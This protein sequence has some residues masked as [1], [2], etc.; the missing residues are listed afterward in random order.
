MQ[1][2]L[3]DLC[4]ESKFIRRLMYP[5]KHVEPT[6]FVNSV[7][8]TMYFTK[9]LILPCCSTIYALFF[10]EKYLLPNYE[11][12]V[13]TY[14]NVYPKFHL[15]CACTYW[16]VGP[17][18]GKIWDIK[19]GCVNNFHQPNYQSF[20]VYMCVYPSFRHNIV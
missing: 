3:A 12:H 10:V 20:F 17:S 9:L 8:L 14:M 13:H 11:L 2:H 6:C 18:T 16:K 15:F 7:L 19:K 1:L 5:K 4:P